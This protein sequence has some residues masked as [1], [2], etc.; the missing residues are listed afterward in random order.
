MLRNQ[1][2]IDQGD[3]NC[4]LCGRPL[5]DCVDAPGESRYCESCNQ[6]FMVKVKKIGN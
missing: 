1:A 2:E 3:V 4:P 6:V 5:W